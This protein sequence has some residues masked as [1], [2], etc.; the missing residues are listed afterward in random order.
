MCRATTY[1]TKVETFNTA[2]LKNK[3]EQEK[4][5]QHC[6]WYCYVYATSTIIKVSSRTK[7]KELLH[8]IDPT[9]ENGS[10]NTTVLHVGAYNLLQKHSSASIGT[11]PLNLISARILKLRIT[12]Q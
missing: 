6:F 3:F 8:H 7:H 4:L 2:V 10:Y 1:A 12:K 9:L 11:L 5:H